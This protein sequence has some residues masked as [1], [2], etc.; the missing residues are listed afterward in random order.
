MK[1]VILLV[2]GCLIF[3]ASFGQ[4]NFIWEKTDSIPKT[5]SQLYSATKMFIAETW[6][7][8]KDVIQNDDKE[9][10]TILIRARREQSISYFLTGYAY[11]YLYDVTFKVKDGKFKIIINNITCKSGYNNEREVYILIQPV[12]GDPYPN[13]TGT[14]SNKKAVQ[15]LTDLKKYFQEIVDSYVLY[16]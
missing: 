12:E 1:K 3:A 6:R 15:L 14:L 13:K 9:T 16:V 10:G 8:S 2:C 4:V 7:S 5:K 11:S